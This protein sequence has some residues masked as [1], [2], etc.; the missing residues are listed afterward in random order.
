MVNNVLD[1]PEDLTAATTNALAD[2]IRHGLTMT[3][4]APAAAEMPKSLKGC[5][6]A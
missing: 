3:N 2:I 5:A 6:S 1:N 4:A